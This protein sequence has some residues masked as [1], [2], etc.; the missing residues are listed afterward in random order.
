MVDAHCTISTAHCKQVSIGA[1]ANN[2][3]L[4]RA[5]A[6]EEGWGGGQAKKQTGRALV[7]VTGA[8]H[9]RADSGG[10][11]Q[12]ETELSQGRSAM[13]LPVRCCLCPLQTKMWD[14]NTRRRRMCKEAM[15][16]GS[17]DRKAQGKSL[18]RHGAD[19]VGARH[20]RK[21]KWRLALAILSRITFTAM[22]CSNAW[23]ISRACTLYVYK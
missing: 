10:S 9:G 11:E 3:N 13:A 8:S 22:L 7:A 1:E 19:C 14:R 17:P 21:G 4:S 23:G 5:V 18:P 15:P 2:K 6:A 20:G 16:A 12:R